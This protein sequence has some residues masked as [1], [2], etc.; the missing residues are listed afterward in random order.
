MVSSRSDL[1]ALAQLLEHGLDA[2]LVDHTE[3]GV[4]DAQAHPALLGF[5]P[6][7]AVLEVRQEASLGLVVGVGH[8][9]PGLG[10]LAGDLADSRHCGGLRFGKAA[11]CTRGSPWPSSE[12]L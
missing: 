4:R 7:A 5:D 9:V 10:L 2:F 6:E 1:A 8:V 3:P 12:F 11:D